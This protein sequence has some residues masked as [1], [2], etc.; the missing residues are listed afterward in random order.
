MFLLSLLF[1]I[2]YVYMKWYTHN[3]SE[4]TTATKELFSHIMDHQAT[5][6]A[7]VITLSGDLGAGKTTMTQI[8]AE[9]IGVAET[10]Q[11]PTFVIKKQYPIQYRNYTELV[12]IDAYRLEGEKNISLFGFSEDFQDPKKIIIIEW[13]EFIGELLPHSMHRVMITDTGESGR[14]ISYEYC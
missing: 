12:H 11:S 3:V 9:N 2:E 1:L 6:Q 14:F 7:V 13:S 4:F 5:H 8:I 10:V